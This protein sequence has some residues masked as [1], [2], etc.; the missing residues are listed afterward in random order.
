MEASSNTENISKALIKAQAAMG[1]AKKGSDNPFF[2]SS[3]AN[4]NAVIEACKDS[5]NQNGISILQPHK[6]L[7]SEG[8][9]FHFV[10]TILKHESGEY[11]SS[12]TPVICAKEN[13]PQALGSGISYARRYGLQSFICLPAEDDDGEQAMGRGQKAASKV[14]PKKAAAPV[15]KEAKAKNSFNRKGNSNGKSNSVF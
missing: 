7:I 4:L 10:E 3:Y 14:A 6:Y 15:S 9:V 11:L 12:S 2:K 5:L 8:K 13:D 1:S